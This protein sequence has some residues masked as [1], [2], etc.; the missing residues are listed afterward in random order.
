VPEDVLAIKGK[1]TDFVES[2]KY[3]ALRIP[4]FL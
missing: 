1:I 3:V 2:M 4:F